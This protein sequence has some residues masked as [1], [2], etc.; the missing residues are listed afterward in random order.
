[1]FLSV[2]GVEMC[3][4]REACVRGGEGWETA[5]AGMP[6]NG[7]VTIIQSSFIGYKKT[8]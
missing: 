3:S 5:D 8:E 4:R 1:M 6:T 7:S 2:D